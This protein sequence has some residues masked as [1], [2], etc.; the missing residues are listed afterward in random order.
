MWCTWIIIIIMMKRV[1]TPV[2][3]RKVTVKGSSILAI[4]FHRYLH[5]VQ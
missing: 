3:A 1:C 4:T 2:A 5:E